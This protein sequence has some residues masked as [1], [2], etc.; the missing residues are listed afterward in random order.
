MN[1]EHLM[2]EAEAMLRAAGVDDARRE[3]E[4]L[5]AGILGVS[6]TVLRLDRDRELGTGETATYRSAVARRSRREPTQYILGRAAFRTLELEVDRRVLIPR[7]ETEELVGAVLAWA[8][9]GVGSVPGSSPAASQA[10]SAR[11]LSPASARSGW[12]DALDVGTGS[13]A[14]ALS[15]AV[16]G[17]FDRIVATDVSEAALA[18][19]RAN[20]RRLELEPRV[21]FRAGDL[22]SAVPAD[23]RFDVIVSN[24]PYIAESER[25]GLM[26]EVREWEPAR[27]LYAGAEGLRVLFALVDGAFERLRAGG[28][29]A[30][31]IGAEQAQGVTER[32]RRAGLTGVGIVSDL[33]GR[34]RILLAERGGT[35]RE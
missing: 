3:G 17:R 16:E 19:A 30:L 10:G 5:L 1:V 27:A 21:E 18:V 35:N 8:A 13:G 22:W 11:M 28:L 26:P 6:R 25:A 32:V 29:L 12:G 34:D 7:P 4:L 31:E 24:P 2:A 20:A 9:A 23:D 33:A 15:L 14:I